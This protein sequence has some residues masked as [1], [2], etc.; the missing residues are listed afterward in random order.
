VVLAV[1]ASGLVGFGQRTRRR[2]RSGRR[3]PPGAS[4]AAAVAVLLLVG[5]VGVVLLA[6]GSSGPAD[7]SQSIDRAPAG[8]ALAALRAVPVKGRAPKT[9]YSR[10][11]FGPA[12]ADVDHNGCDTRDDILRRDLTAIQVRASTHGCVVVAGLL[13]D[14][15]TGKR[16]AFSKAA[17]SKVQIDHVV[18]LSD[19]WQTG[20][21]GWSPTVRR[22]F[23]NDPLELLAVDG[24]ANQ[25]K[26]DGD[27]ATWLPPQKSFRCAYVSRQ[28]AVK[29]RYHL[30]VTAAERDAIARVLQKCPATA[31]P[32]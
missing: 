9:G 3:P 21:Q 13:A 7:T 16:I 8:S 14:P 17:A 6:G 11:E 20:A 18:A 19:A 30:C 32:S 27:A 12:W 15:Y 5:L 28:V 29:L 26:G 24:Q 23:A 25:D 2:R 22:D 1:A 10:A 31:L 4:A